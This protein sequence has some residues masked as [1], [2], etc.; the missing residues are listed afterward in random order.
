MKATTLIALGALIVGCAN[1]TQK[2]TE[3][4]A[5]ENDWEVL[6]DGTST[7]KWKQ[8]NNDTMSE[9]W[10]IEDGALVFYPPKKGSQWGKGHNIVTKENYHSF[11]LVYQGSVANFPV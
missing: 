4:T 1:P 2:A 10:K 8:Y 11:E 3:T 6:F 9:A 5:Q 7:D